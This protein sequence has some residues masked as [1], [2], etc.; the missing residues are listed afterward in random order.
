MMV[1]NIG[2][3][4]FAQIARSETTNGKLLLITHCAEGGLV[5]NERQYL[6]LA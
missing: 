2:V 4:A 6:G 3:S 5:L 1:A